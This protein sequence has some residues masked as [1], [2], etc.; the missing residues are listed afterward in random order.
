MKKGY[1]LLSGGKD[2]TLT[3]YEMHMEGRLAGCI[4]ID[5][6]IG[7][8]ETKDYVVKVCARY[9]WKLYV[10][11]GYR[12]YEQYVRKAGFPHYQQHNMVMHVLKADAIKRAIS[13]IKQETGEIPLLFSGVRIRES[14][15]RSKWVKARGKLFNAEVE[16]PIA[17]LSDGEVWRR[18]KEY[19]IPLNPSY[20]TIGISGDC[21]CGS[22]ST[23]PEKQLLRLYYPYMAE[24]ISR[25]ESVA[26]GSSWKIRIW[27]NTLSSICNLEKNAT[28]DE[29]EIC[30]ECAHHAEAMK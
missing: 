15:N 30:S 24:E 21:L 22:F 8:A 27:G 28:L 13:R 1:A 17:N 20:E 10:T 2:S 26:A 6:S 23:L 11:Q 14:R 3:A 29:M 18:I 4:Y 5:T 25:L 16:N 9:G 19:D 12:T 7:L